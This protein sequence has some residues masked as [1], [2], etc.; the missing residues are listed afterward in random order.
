MDNLRDRDNYSKIRIDVPA[1]LQGEGSKLRGIMI[2][3]QAKTRTSVPFGLSISIHDVFIVDIRRIHASKMDFH[4]CHL[5]W[6]AKF[7]FD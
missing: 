5:P 2:A 4:G 6:A 1:T 3:S 7:T